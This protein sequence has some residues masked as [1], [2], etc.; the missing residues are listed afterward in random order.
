MIG[1]WRSERIDIRV[2]PAAF[3]AIGKTGVPIETILSHHYCMGDAKAWNRRIAEAR[4]A[5]IVSNTEIWG[6]DLVEARVNTVTT[7]DRRS[8]R[9]VL[10]FERERE[11]RTGKAAKTE[12]LGYREPEHAGEVRAE[13]QRETRVRKVNGPVQSY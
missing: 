4:G 7:P 3:R 13:R 6:D 8:T 11:V 1:Q 9:I 2:S 10:E 12:S 5:E